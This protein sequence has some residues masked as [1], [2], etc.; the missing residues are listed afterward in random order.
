MQ[1]LPE[2]GF[3]PGFSGGYDA[4]Q[5]GNYVTYSLDVA[6]FKRLN[7]N[8]GELRGM[9]LD[10]LIAHEIG[11][12]PLGASALGYSHLPFDGSDSGEINVTRYK[13]NACRLEIGLDARKSSSGI[14]IP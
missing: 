10:A 14:P 11:H 9:R 6:G 5:E 8:P 2:S 1:T 12:T 4:S 13:E 7:G 3:L